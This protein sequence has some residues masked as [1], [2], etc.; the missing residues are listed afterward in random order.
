VRVARCGVD[1]RSTKRAAIGFG[2]HQG[3]KIARAVIIA[4]LVV[5]VV[6]EGL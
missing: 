3:L 1:V 5:V 6:R 2:A 4:V